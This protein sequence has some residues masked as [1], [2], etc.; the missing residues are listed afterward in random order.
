VCI[1]S[2]PSVF[3]PHHAPEGKAVVHAYT[4][5]NE[6]Y[7]IW[8]NLDRNTP[9]YRRLKVWPALRAWQGSTR[10]EDEGAQGGGGEA[11][12]REY[13]RGRRASG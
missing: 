1:A 3:T 7:S 11:E 8:E 13:E 9:A 10:G 12:V 2:I 5:G 6:P 4:A